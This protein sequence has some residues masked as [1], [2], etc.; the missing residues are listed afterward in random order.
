MYAA[1]MITA[2]QAGI[3]FSTSL[4]TIVFGAG[5][6]VMQALIEVKKRIAN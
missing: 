1:D 3:M 6:L 2:K 5:N 4:G